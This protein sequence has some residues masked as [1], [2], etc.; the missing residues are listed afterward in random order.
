[1][2]WTRVCVSLLLL[3]CVAAGPVAL[4]DHTVDATPAAGSSSHPLTNHRRAK[5]AAAVGHEDGGDSDHSF[6]P[7]QVETSSAPLLGCIGGSGEYSLSMSAQQCVAV[8]G[9][10]QAGRDVTLQ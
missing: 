7:M 3:S 1:M 6:H 9:T 2:A 10:A 8:H 4:Y 5:H